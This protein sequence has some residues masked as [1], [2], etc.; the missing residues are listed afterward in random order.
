MALLW[1]QKGTYIMTINENSTPNRIIKFLDTK[2]VGTTFIY[3]D[4]TNCGDYESIRS[5][6]V[7]LCKNRKL[8]RVCQGVYVKPKSGG[9]MIKPS[10]YQII[11]DID[12]RNGGTPIPKGEETKN[13]IEGTLH[14]KPKELFFYTNSSTRQIRLP[15]G[16]IV[17]FYHRNN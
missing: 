9:I 6:V 7:H 8:I 1:L 16:I 3:D 11:K 17:K 4:F 10:D 13:Y 5:A 12:R 2:D 15:N 14:Y